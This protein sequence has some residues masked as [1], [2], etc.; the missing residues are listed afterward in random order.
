MIRWE[1][2]GKGSLTFRA[3]V[4][5]ADDLMLD[6]SGYWDKIDRFGD[7]RWG[8]ALRFRGHLVRS[9]DMA[10]SHKN[11]GESGRIRGPHKQRFLS[12]K[13]DRYA[14]TPD[15]SISM[16]TP[17]AALRDFLKECNIELLEIYY[18]GFPA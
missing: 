16:N 12:S 1:P 5:T 18:E 6:L 14:Y 3:S 9:Y 2:T 15:P 17:S 7:T 13:M 10:K 11:P 4:R 8:F